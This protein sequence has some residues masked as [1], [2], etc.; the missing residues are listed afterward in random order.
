MFVY[1]DFLITFIACLHAVRAYLFIL[2]NDACGDAMIDRCMVQRG[3]AC[4]ACLCSVHVRGS[5]T[6]CALPT[7]VS[8][9]G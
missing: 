4:A 5:A 8:G 1:A 7:S 3:G 2:S 6:A 9:A